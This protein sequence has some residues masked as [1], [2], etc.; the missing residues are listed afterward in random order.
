MIVPRCSMALTLLFATGGWCQDAAKEKKMLEGK[1]LPMQA[2]HAGQ[3]LPEA[4]LK[5]LSLDIADGTYT[6]KAGNVVDKGTLKI[7]PAAK[8]KAMD[9]VGTD[10]P[11]K[12]KTFLAI[13]EFKGD[14]LRICYDLDGKARPTEFVTSKDRPFFL[15]VYQRAKS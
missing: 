8:P 6:V 5:S 1:W 9:I 15:A 11:N 2:E 10:G 13:Y 3:K 4:Q 12:G 7:D 14:T